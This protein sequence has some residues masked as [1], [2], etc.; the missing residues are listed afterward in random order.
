MTGQ[1]ATAIDPEGRTVT[2]ESGRTLGYDR[3]DAHLQT[4]LPGIYTCGDCV[5]TVDACTG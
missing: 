2:T 4:N 3:V 1:R 5:E